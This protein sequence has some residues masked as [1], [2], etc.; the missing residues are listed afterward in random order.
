MANLMRLPPPT[1][2]Q[3][4]AELNRELLMRQSVYP[5]MVF[6]KRLRQHEADHRNACLRKAHD[7]LL[8]LYNGQAP[9]RD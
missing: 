7:D 8:E 9:A 5:N 6:N 3:V 2:A 4:I 1:H